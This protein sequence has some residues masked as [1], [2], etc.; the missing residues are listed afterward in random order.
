MSFDML[1]MVIYFSYFVWPVDSAIARLVL[2][3]LFQLHNLACHPAHHKPKDLD[4]LIPS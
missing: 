2:K 3:P 4:E 1:G